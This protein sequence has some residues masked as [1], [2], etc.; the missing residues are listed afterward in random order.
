M[1][2]LNASH[3]ILEYQYRDGGNFKSWGTIL[4]VGDAN[5]KRKNELISYL[6]DRTWFVAERLGL[7]L[8]YEGV[9]KW[10]SSELDNTWHEF[11]DL[12]PATDDEIRITPCFGS[13]YDLLHA[14]QKASEHWKF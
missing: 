2:T 14:F 6:I 9:S 3:S 5:E 4:L 13:L 7:P 12:R 10:G 8:L 1:N 11:I